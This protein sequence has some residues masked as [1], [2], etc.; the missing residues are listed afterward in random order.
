MNHYPRAVTA[1]ETQSVALVGSSSL[2]ASRRAQG[3]NAQNSLRTP[4]VGR[5]E[6]SGILHAADDAKEV[7]NDTSLLTA[8]VLEAADLAVRSPEWIDPRSWRLC[9][10]GEDD[11]AQHEA[12]QQAQ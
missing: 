6:D 5:L 4:M 8:A 11:L 9:Q 7:L 1:L 2:P 12:H 10:I 3:A